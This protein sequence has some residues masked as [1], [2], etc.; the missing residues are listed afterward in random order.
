MSE[1]VETGPATA[2][3]GGRV[4]KIEHKGEGGDFFLLNVVNLILTGLTLGIYTFW[5]KT[6][7]RHYLWAHTEFDGEPFEY[8][9]RGLELFLGALIVG[10]FLLP[11]LWFLGFGFEALL[12]SGQAVLAVVL[13]LSLFVGFFFLIGV[14]EYR[15]RQYQMSRT[16]WRG[17]AMSLEGSTMKYAVGVF[18]R[19]ILNVITLGFSTPHLELYQAK[20]FLGGAR[21]GSGSVTTNYNPKELYRS[22]LL[23]YGLAFL[24]MLIPLI[25]L[26]PA[27]VELITASVSGGPGGNLDGLEDAGATFQSVVFGTILLYIAI[28]VSVIPYSI[29]QARKWQYIAQR[30][31]FEIGRATCKEID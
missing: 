26:V 1:V 12:L 11:V 15:A 30:T 6:R 27:Y 4:Y 16:R 19:R 9:G 13:Q 5:A 31:M 23:A 21:F 24:I 14:A 3:S 20:Q 28:M 18:F 10:L 2:E 29:Y 22:F 7:V 8:T 17:I 25:L